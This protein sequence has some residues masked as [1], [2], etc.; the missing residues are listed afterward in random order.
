VSR[1]GF[2]EVVEEAEEVPWVQWRPSSGCEVSW[3]R[4]ALSPARP[5]VPTLRA[6]G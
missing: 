1:R 6:P 4:G 5:I 3:R 2:F